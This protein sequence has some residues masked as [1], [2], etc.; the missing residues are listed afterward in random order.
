MMFVI[1]SHIDFLQHVKREC[2]RYKINL[3][4]TED[5]CFHSNGQSYGGYFTHVARE[6][7]VTH[8]N[9]EH[10]FISIL[11]HEFSHMEQWIDEDPTYTQHLRGGHES[12]TIMDNWLN[13][14]E[15]EFNTIKKC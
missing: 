2:R 6:L 7:G 11:V 13:G 1:K 8:L 12:S 14:V 4:L 3:V 10:L 5:E 15:Y 9:S